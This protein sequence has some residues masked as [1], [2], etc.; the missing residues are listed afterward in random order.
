MARL[1]PALLLALLAAAPASAAMR[2]NGE[3]SLC[4]RPFDKVV[5]PATHNSMSAESLGW[6]LPNQQVGIPEQLRA[7]IRGLLFDT[8]Y[9]RR[10]PD[11]SVTKVERGAPGAE[12]YLCH[13]ICEGGAT[14][15]IETLTAMRDFLR[16]R[17][18]NVIAV[19]NEDSVAP[20]DFARAVKKSG[21]RRHV[22]KRKPGPRWPKL[23]KM[24]R[25]R[26]QVV[27][28]AE[29][30]ATGVPWYHVAY[31]G[32]L[33]ETPYSWPAPPQLTMP[34]NWESSCVPNRGGTSGSLFLMN[35][36]SPPLGANPAAAA[37]VNAEA[38]IVGRAQKCREVRGLMPTIVA[39]DMFQSGDLFSAVRKLNA[40]L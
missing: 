5:L 24:I 36:W 8:Y 32:I 11:G 13:S 18:N 37:Q 22:Y 25:S 38:A 27:M 26:G 35:H 1:L 29:R 23:R 19:I 30:D 6:K 34:Q 12:L 33:Q 39:V 40:S 21:L 4:G 2:C 15:L 7:G 20:K 28:L 3:R 9:A 31:E 17:P 16:A 14:P 10:N